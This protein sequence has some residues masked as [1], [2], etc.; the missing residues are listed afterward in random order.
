M[1]ACASCRVDYRL[2][3]MIHKVECDL[4]QSHETQIIEA[5]QKTH[6]EQRTGSKLLIAR[7]HNLASRPRFM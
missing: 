3:A 6:G 2:A 4:V 1:H 7:I 5:S